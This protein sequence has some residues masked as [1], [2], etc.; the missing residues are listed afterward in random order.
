M[1]DTVLVIAAHP[2]DEVLGCGGAIAKHV[3]G[4]DE[5]HV[6]IL[7]EGITS[8]TARRDA[9]TAAGELGALRQSAERAHQVLG[10]KS[11]HLHDFP[12]NRMD[13]VDLLDIVKVVEQYVAQ[14]RPTIVY[15]HHAGD[16]NIDHRRIHDAVIVACRP[17][18]NSPGRV[19][20]MLFFEVASNT[21][22][23]PPGSAESFSPNWF[24]DVSA[25]LDTKLQS[26]AEYESE[27]RCWPHPRSRE[28]V[29]YLAR[30]RGAT[31]GVQA[32]EAFVLGRQIQ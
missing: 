29:E 10:S 3:K 7:A 26:L 14:F 20:T 28:A 1:A 5:V 30:W 15:T 17:Q 13:S 25:E 6:C 23:Q 2:D 19:S 31:I 24:V 32:A 22:W 18:P 12:D 27:M 21:E 8:R 16:V 11:L 9:A 4:G